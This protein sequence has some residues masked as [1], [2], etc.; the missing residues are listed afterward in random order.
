MA[1]AQSRMQECKDA[2]SD[3]KEKARAAIAKQPLI[4]DDDDDDDVDDAGRTEKQNAHL[5]DGKAKGR[6]R[7]TR[8]TLAG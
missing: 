5:A 4:V 3:A 1:A 2:A 7:K 8:K 6:T